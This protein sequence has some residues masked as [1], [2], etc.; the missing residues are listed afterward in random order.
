[1]TTALKH[2]KL[3]QDELMTEAA[4]LFGDD[5]MKWAFRCPH[6]GD[7]ATPADFKE[8]GASPGMAGQECIGRSLGALKKPKPTNTR[9]CDWAAYGLFRGPWEVVVPAEGDK[10]ERSIWAF[11]LAVPEPVAADA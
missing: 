1:M 8:A 2:R 5:P 4:A 6:C 9:G 11:P 3:T 10:P 7:V